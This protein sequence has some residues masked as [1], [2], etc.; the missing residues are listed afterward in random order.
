MVRRFLLS[1]ALGALLLDEPA[2]LDRNFV[3]HIERD[4]ETDLTD[5]IRRRQDGGDDQDSDQSVFALGGRAA[6]E[7]SPARISSVSRTGN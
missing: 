7:I 1:L 4:G 3:E 5:D 6:E 2:D